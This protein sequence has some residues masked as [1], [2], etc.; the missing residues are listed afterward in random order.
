MNK[1]YEKPRMNF[2]SVQNE[3]KVAANCWS[4]V[5]NNTN[6]DGIWVYDNNH[7]RGD[8]YIVF[9]ID[10]NCDGTVLSQLYYEKVDYR[11]P[12]AQGIALSE[13]RGNEAVEGFLKY[14]KNNNGKLDKEDSSID[15]YFKMNFTNV[16][17]VYPS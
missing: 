12:G 5:A 16:E 13:K 17:G 10:E 14:D 11:E 15:N 9:Q 6:D 2:V 3:N 4:Q 1:I 7:N 8:G